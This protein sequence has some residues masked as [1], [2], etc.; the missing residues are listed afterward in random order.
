MTVENHGNQSEQWK[1]K[2]LIQPGASLENYSI[3]SCTLMNYF[4]NKSACVYS[5]TR[6]ICIYGTYLHL[7]AAV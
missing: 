6:H 3:I 4:Y 5:K 1:I 2:S 7:T